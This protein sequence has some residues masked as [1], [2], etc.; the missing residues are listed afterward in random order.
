MFHFLVNLQYMKNDHKLAN[1]LEDPNVEEV[2]ETADI[3][4]PD[5]FVNW[6][7]PLLNLY[8]VELYPGILPWY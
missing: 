6:R 2:D 5:I 4:Q 7:S 3:L 8:T 1:Y